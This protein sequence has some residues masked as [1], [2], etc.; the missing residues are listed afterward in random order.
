[1]SNLRYHVFRKPKKLRNGKTVHRWYYY[2][3]DENGKQI[4][5]SCGT[6]V[7]NRNAA[8]DFVRSLPP[9]PKAATASP[10]DK[11]GLLLYSK[12]ANNP[13]MLVKDIASEMFLPGTMHVKR[14]QQLKKSVAEETLCANRVFMTHIT[15]MWGDRMLRTLELDEIMNYLF[16][17]DRSA[18]W[19]NQYIVN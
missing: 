2:W 16:N 4:Q 9:P 7:K 6:S 8:G 10:C 5:K 14:R 12:P 11:R 15:A 19:K 17:V 18:S 13:D 1:M 3:I